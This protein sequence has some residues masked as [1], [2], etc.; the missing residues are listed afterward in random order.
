MHLRQIE[1]LKLQIIQNRRDSGSGNAPNQNTQL[2]R[3][4]DLLKKNIEKLY[5]ELREMCEANE[6]LSVGDEDNFEMIL[7]SLRKHLEQ[8]KHKLALLASDL[9][10]REE[11]LARLTR[12][13][14]QTSSKEQK[15]KQELERLAQELGAATAQNKSLQSTIN[16]LNMQQH[17]LELELDDREHKLNEAEDKLAKAQ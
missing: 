16:H 17:S 1:Q 14:D 3:E 6:L 12:R 10:I 11:E 7:S 9:K 5:D 13:L 15:P 2:V 8:G 4:N